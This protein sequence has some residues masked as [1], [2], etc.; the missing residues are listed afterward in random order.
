MG[1]H[2]RPEP[3]YL[4]DGAPAAPTQSRYPWRT[5][6]R[7]AVQFLIAFAPLAPVIVTASGVDEATAGVAGMLAVFAGITRIMAVPRVNT[8]LE[9]W[10]PWLAAE[11]RTGE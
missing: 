4:A 9:R 3:A 8:F 5:T 7:S 10:A 2:R 11:P 6:V 1:R